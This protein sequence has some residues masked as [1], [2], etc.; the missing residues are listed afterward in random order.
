MIIRREQFEVF[1]P[2]AELAFIDEMVEQLLEEHAD[3]EV[4]LPEQMLSLEE[5]PE[6]MLRVMVLKGVNRARGY[7]IEE[8]SSIASFVSLMFVVAPNFDEHPL[9]RRI[10]SDERHP[11]DSRID[12]LWEQT[13]EDNWEAAEEMYNPHAWQVNLPTE[14]PGDALAGRSEN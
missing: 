2:V 1:E 4:E 5:I 7:G 3:V 6:E 13:S 12:L 10:L 8:Q 11:S 14:R 9:I